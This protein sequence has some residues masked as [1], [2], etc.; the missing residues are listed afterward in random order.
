MHDR[1]PKAPWALS[2]DR[3]FHADPAQRRVARDLYAGVV[4]LPLICPHGH[5]PPALLSDPAARFGSPTELFI[6]PDHYVTRM[7]YSQGV[8]LGDLGVPSRD[9][10]P[11]E[12]DHRT[13]WQR[14]AVRFHLFRATPTGLWLATKSRRIG[15]GYLP[16]RHVRLPTLRD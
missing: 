11:V 2:P 6:I 10:S 13:I 4:G 3:C 12:A 7:L 8:P 5:V 9:G 16:G 1:T 15:R 14:F